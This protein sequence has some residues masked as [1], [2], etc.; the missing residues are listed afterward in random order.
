MREAPKGRDLHLSGALRSLRVALFSFGTSSLCPRFPISEPNLKQAQGRH[1]P[2]IHRT[3]QKLACS[4]PGFTLHLRGGY[5]VA[6][7]T[8]GVA[9]QNLF[10]WLVANFEATRAMAFKVLM[11]GIFN[12]TRVEDSGQTALEGLCPSFCQTNNTR[13]LNTEQTVFCSVFKLRKIR[14]R[15]IGK[16]LPLHKISQ[17][18]LFKRTWAN[19]HLLSTGHL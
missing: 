10:A 9:G 17:P 1:T 11:F 2:H 8:S 4:C 16:I 19:K 3:Q 12:H 13:P 7:K 15:S 5:K 6:F 18:F 14:T